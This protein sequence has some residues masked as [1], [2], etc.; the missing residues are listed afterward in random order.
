[1]SVDLFQLSVS[2]L[3]VAQKMQDNVHL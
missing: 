2:K 3:G 1:M